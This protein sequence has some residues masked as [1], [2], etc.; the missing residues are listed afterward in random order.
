VF[1]VATTPLVTTACANLVRKLRET[2]GLAKISRRLADKRSA[3]RVAEA[4]QLV[5]ASEEL[6]QAAVA[7]ERNRGVSW[8]TIGEALGITRSTAH[9]RF[10][11]RLENGTDETDAERE[12]HLAWRRIRTMA[13]GHLA[14]LT[15]GVA[16][17]E[18]GS[19]QRVREDLLA[20]SMEPSFP[21]ELRIG[22]AQLLATLEHGEYAEAMERLL[23]DAV[24]HSASAEL[25]PAAPIR[26]GAEHGAIS[27]LGLL[28][29]DACGSTPD[30]A[31]E[32]MR[33]VLLD[34]AVEG[35]SA[36]LDKLAADGADGSARQRNYE[37][38]AA[39]LL[40]R[41]DRQAN[42]DDIVR[43]VECLRSARSAGPGSSSP[44][45]TELLAA[46]LRR[47]Y[48]QGG[49]PDDLAEAV[50]LRR[51]V[52]TD[53]TRSYGPDHMETL[54][55][56]FEL[57]QELA[58]AGDAEPA[59][60]LFDELLTKQLRQLGQDHPDVLRT[61]SAYARLLSKS[62]DYLKAEQILAD[63]VAGQTESLGSD[64]PDTVASRAQLLKVMTARLVDTADAELIEN[65]DLT[66]WPTLADGLIGRHEW[67]LLARDE[68][69]ALPYRARSF[70][71]HLDLDQRPGIRGG[72]P[73]SDAAP[74]SDST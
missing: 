66:A 32:E 25:A 23:Q 36:L 5:L 46:A 28:I 54:K 17:L 3:R 59:G 1:D 69:S 65:F 35:F 74:K 22:A 31:A 68:R 9:G 57:A 72:L 39:A 50:R 58:I 63:L 61:R 70:D 30:R 71:A 15:R 48:R 49:D 7:A 52:V 16:E 67:P 20:A 34:Y 27:P 21:V 43:A 44:E 14:P 11:D 56:R 26:P 8:E 64:H 53:R 41:F 51:R 40:I 47:S 12:L 4:H 38:L 29:V 45:A 33:A 24:A 6:L 37:R 42:P 2:G 13:E 55:A 73:G 62:G 18:P 19:R 10:A 60:K